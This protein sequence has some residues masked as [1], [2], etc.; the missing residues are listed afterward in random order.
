MADDK[1]AF[2]KFPLMGQ[3]NKKVDAKIK[4]LKKFVNTPKDKRTEAQKKE[5]TPK[6][7]REVYDIMKRGEQKLKAKTTK[8]K[9]G[10]KLAAK[11]KQSGHN[12]LY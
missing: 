5:F 12:R 2:K 9:T 7:I 10:G 8:K 11:K 3:H 4:R 1:Y 6:V